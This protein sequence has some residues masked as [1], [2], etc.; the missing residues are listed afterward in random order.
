[1]HHFPTRRPPFHLFAVSVSQSASSLQF[2]F[3]F[4]LLQAGRIYM[5]LNINQLLSAQALFLQ[6]KLIH[7]RVIPCVC[8]VVTMRSWLSFRWII[9]SDNNGDEDRTAIFSLQMCK[10]AARHFSSRKIMRCGGEKKCSLKPI[11]SFFYHQSDDF[12]NSPCR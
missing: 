1:M 5:H 8:I 10:E 11:F 7:L 12:Q 4:L 2:F 6:F 3:S 9:N